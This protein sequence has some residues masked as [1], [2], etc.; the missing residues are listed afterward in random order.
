MRHP[1]EGQEGG[2]RRRRE[3]AAEAAGATEEGGRSGEA[4]EGDE[5]PEGKADP[6]SGRRSCSRLFPRRRRGQ[7]RRPPAD[8]PRRRSIRPHPPGRHRG[9]GESTPALR[10]RVPVGIEPLR[11]LV[12]Q[13]ARSVPRAAA[14]RFDDRRAGAGHRRRP[15]R[16]P[17]SPGQGLGQED[18]REGAADGPKR[19]PGRAQGIGDRRGARPPFQGGAEPPRHRRRWARDPR[20]GG[21]RH[22]GGRQDPRSPRRAFGRRAGEGGPPRPG[23]SRQ[24]ARPEVPPAAEPARRRERPEEG[25]PVVREP[26]G[27]RGRQPGGPERRG[28]RARR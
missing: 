27:R 10:L 21:R 25:A 13:G 2:V 14:P 22:P 12:G 9:A 3:G 5:S 17:S 24:D 19:G 7:V 1:R 26:P 20:A 16:A 8:L 23:R 28:A 18:Q 15:P 6:A 4:A 11:P